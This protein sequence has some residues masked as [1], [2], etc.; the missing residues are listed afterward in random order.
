MSRYF[1]NV[2]ALHNHL[3]GWHM[4]SALP[5]SKIETQTLSTAA[6]PLPLDLDSPSGYTPTKP[7][8]RLCLCRLVDNQGASLC[9]VIISCKTE[10]RLH[11]PPSD[12][13]YAKVST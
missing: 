10:N 9:F 11:V 3:N 4:Y 2:R 13:S 12:V 7:L 5:F 6:Y 1:G 8:F